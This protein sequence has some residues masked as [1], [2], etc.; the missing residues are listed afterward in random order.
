MALG[1]YAALALLA[2]LTLDGPLRAMVWIL[3]GGLA[4][5]TLARAK[6]PLEP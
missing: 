2:Y 3:C 4:V 6:P 5:M 1:A